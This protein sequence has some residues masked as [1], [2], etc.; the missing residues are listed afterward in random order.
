MHRR[1]IQTEQG[2][3][4]RESGTSRTVAIVPREEL[5]EVLQPAERFAKEIRAVPRLVAYLKTRAERG[6]SEAKRILKELG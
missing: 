4:V 5:F 1:I 3:V 6:D 2:F